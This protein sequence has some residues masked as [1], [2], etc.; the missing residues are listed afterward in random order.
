MRIIHL[1]LSIMPILTGLIGFET[2]HAQENDALIRLLEY[3][4]ERYPEMQADDVYKLLYQGTMGAG[5]FIK[6]PEGAR[7]YLD[8]E[9]AR[10]VSNREIPLMEQV[11]LEGDLVRLNIAPY[12]AS[13]GDAE[14]LF[15]AVMKTVEDFQPSKTDLIDLLEKTFRLAEA[16]IIPIDHME[17][18]ELMEEAAGHDY[19][20]VHHSEV[21]RETYDPAYRVIL[22]KYAEEIIIN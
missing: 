22:R 11:S 3:H 2:G 20:A 4:L 15:R 1:Y 18:R 16:K 10:V 6:N 5:H 19:P 21:Y 14:S 7:K 8:S 17:F 9:S 12:K 13:G